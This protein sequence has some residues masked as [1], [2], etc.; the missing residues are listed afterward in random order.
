[1]MGKSPLS[2]LTQSLGTAK[3]LQIPLLSPA[4]KSMYVSLNPTVCGVGCTLRYEMHD[5]LGQAENTSIDLLIDVVKLVITLPSEI[6]QIH[7][8]EDR[9]C[10]VD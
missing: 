6:L 7:Y 9:G 8:S 2:P 4:C 3:S 5:S 1:M 10:F